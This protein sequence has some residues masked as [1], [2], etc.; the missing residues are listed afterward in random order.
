M[1]MMQEELAAQRVATLSVPV[2]AAGPPARG[3]A[4]CNPAVL[5]DRSRSGLVHWSCPCPL[6]LNSL[7]MA[8]V[9]RR[10]QVSRS[11]VANA[12]P[13]LCASSGCGRPDTISRIIWAHSLGLF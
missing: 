9:V 1:R 11:G 2:L 6:N 3:T 8:L 12:P 7:L 5:C 10:S 4:L 13:T